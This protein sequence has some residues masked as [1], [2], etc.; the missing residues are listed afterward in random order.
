MAPIM[1]RRANILLLLALAAGVAYGR[2]GLPFLLA[3]GSDDDGA[4]FHEADLQSRLKAD[5]I[6]FRMFL[7]K[8]G[9]EEDEVKRVLGLL[10]QSPADAARSGNLQVDKYEIDRRHALWL[11]YDYNRILIKA[12]LTCDWQPVHELRSAR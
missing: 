11:H 10:E 1:P 6:Y 5:K 8:P 12:E 9:M 7:L 3:I 4:M 2:F